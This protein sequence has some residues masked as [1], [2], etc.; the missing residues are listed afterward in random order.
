[1]ATASYLDRR[2]MASDL[3]GIETVFFVSRLEVEDRTRHHET[4]LDGLVKAGLWR[5]FTKDTK[6]A[7]F[8]LFS[9]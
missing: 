2:A 3:R 8:W 5:Q 1:M 9:K 7:S 6:S 4:A